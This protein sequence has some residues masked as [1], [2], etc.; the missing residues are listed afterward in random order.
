MC[1]CVCVSVCARARVRVYAL[2]W[3]KQKEATI[4]KESIDG[5]HLYEVQEQTKHVYHERNQSNG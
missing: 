3:V 1:V 5:F 4:L 2:D